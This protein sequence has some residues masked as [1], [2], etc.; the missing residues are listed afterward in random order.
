[1][2]KALR[3]YFLAG[4][5]VLVPMVITLWVL[6]KFVTFVEVRLGAYFIRLLELIGF[7]PIPG[8]GFISVV[9]VILL[10]GV[11]TRYWIGRL[12]ISWGDRFLG[13]LPVVSRVYKLIKQVVD[14]FFKGDRRVFERVV[15][16]EF[17]RKGTYSIGFVTGNTG[18]ILADQLAP[19]HIGG[20]RHDGNLRLHKFS[21]NNEKTFVNW[22]ITCFPDSS[23]KA[24]VKTPYL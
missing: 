22:P 19:R 2:F 5:L 21:M 23:Y 12:F 7:P 13:K 9:F 6:I 10:T 20:G 15:L 18:G 8:Y 14:A 1:M 4:L 16:V 11:L 24:S 17:P 3:S